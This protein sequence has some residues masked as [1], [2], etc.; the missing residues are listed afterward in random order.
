MQQAMAIGQRLARMPVGNAWSDTRLLSVTRSNNNYTVSESVAGNAAAMT[1]RG[2]SSGKFYWETGMSASGTFNCAAGMRRED[3]AIGTA[4][5]LGKTLAMRSTAALF[6]G[7]TGATSGT[8]ATFATTARLM[9]AVDFAAAKYWI[10][11]NNVWTNSGNPA[12][13][14]GALFTGWPAGIWHPYVWADNDAGGA[15]T[16]VLYNGQIE[17]A[18]SYTPPDG[19][20]K[21][22]RY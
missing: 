4:I 9:H 18:M 7:D 22:I 14:T 20:E 13:G 5:N 6:V 16:F 11:V 3:E 12:A 21:G 17:N 1:Y 8:G 2:R 10:G 19:F 15:H